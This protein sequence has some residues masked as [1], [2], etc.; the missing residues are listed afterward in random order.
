SLYELDLCAGVHVFKLKTGGENLSIHSWGAAIDLSH[1]IN[2]WKIKHSKDPKKKMMPL[3]VVK[4]FEDEDWTWGGKWKYADA[5][6]FQAAN[7]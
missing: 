6:H 4:L 2:G 1:L 7:I 5:M 3:E